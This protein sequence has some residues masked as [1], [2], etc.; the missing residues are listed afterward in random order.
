MK[1]AAP[2]ALLLAACAYDPAPG[3]TMSK[4]A[5]RNL[6]CNRISQAEAHQRYP[7]R[8]P[9]LPPRGSYSNIDALVCSTKISQPGDRP[10]RDDVVLTSMR[11][12]VGEI[13]RLANALVPRTAVWHVDTFYPE[14]LVAQKL[15]VA[16]RTDL[17][18][19]GHKV[20]DR[21][22]VLAPGD[23]AVLARLEPKKAYPLACAR[24]FKEKVLTDPDAFLGMMIMDARE[25]DLHAGI[26]VRGEWKWLK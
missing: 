26:C 22:P 20:S 21:V 3:I 12:S 11:E 18:E 5:S 25:T 16:A 9:D 14:Q 2:I 15:S 23:I 8:V 6:E 10:A 19:R 24:Y 13:T 4:A 7:G 17:A 1:A